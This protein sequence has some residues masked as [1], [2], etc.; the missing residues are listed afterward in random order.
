MERGRKR[1]E[2]KRQSSS[3]DQDV[4]SIVRFLVR[5]RRTKEYRE[6]FFSKMASSASRCGKETRPSLVSPAAAAAE[7]RHPSAIQRPRGLAD[8]RQWLSPSIGSRN[9]LA[10][11][12]GPIETWQRRASS[13][14]QARRA[15]TNFPFPRIPPLQARW[16][17]FS[18]RLPDL[19]TDPLLKKR[20]ATSRYACN[21]GPVA[22]T[23]PTLCPGTQGRLFP[24]RSPTPSLYMTLYEWRLLTRD[25]R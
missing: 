23:S 15:R 2:V 13:G 9:Y 20:V 21:R 6:L 18:S 11:P 24:L 22:A 8:G 19:L 17:P 3:L 7:S 4:S 16:S 14:P 5:E 12:A 1:D 10:F 25:C